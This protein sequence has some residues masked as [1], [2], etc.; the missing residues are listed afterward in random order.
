MRTRAPTTTFLIDDSNSNIQQRTIINDNNPSNDSNNQINI[1]SEAKL[2][3]SHK[4]SLSSLSRKSKR[5]SGKA[6]N[7][8]FGLGQS[9]RFYKQNRVEAY[10]PCANDRK[11]EFGGNSSLIDQNNQNGS[12]IRQQIQIQL[13]QSTVNSNIHLGN[14]VTQANYSFN[15]QNPRLE[16]QQAIQNGR[17]NSN[18]EEE[19][20][21]TNSDNRSPTL[22]R[23]TVRNNLH[24]GSL[25]DNDSPSKLSDHDCQRCLDL[26]KKHQLL[27]HQF[28]LDQDNINVL[29]R[30]L[31]EV[32]TENETVKA[33]LVEHN[34]KNE[35][36]SKD[37]VQLIKANQEQDNAILELT[38]AINKISPNFFKEIFKN[39]VKSTDDDQSDIERRDAEADEVIL[40]ESSSKKRK[41]DQKQMNKKLKSQKITQNQCLN[42]QS[43]LRGSSSLLKSKRVISMAPAI[44][45]EKA[46][47]S[48]KPTQNLRLQS[49]AITKKIEQRAR[50]SKSKKVK[51]QNRAH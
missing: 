33:L 8:K 2:K 30:A 20:I 25:N 31:S 35:K 13:P 9:K 22:N 11:Q 37:N 23:S 34:I 42:G 19:K 40:N 32:I 4:K 21:L 26:L 16:N 46:K 14:Q 12:E 39:Q 3:S 1:D 45:I 18:N 44:D 28:S 29:K 24:L 38:Q 51:K 41:R 17:N 5:K 7:I 6:T 47:K 36:L 43:N 15:E 49:K 27:R 10:F 48:S 50:Q